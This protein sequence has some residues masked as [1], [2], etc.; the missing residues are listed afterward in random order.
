MNK[1]ERQFVN[2]INLIIPAKEISTR[3][4]NKNLLDLGGK[5]LVYRACE[6]CLKSQNISN[7]FIDTESDKIINSIKDLIPRGLRVI[8]RPASL[9]SNKTSG[10]DLIDFEL[11]KI[12]KCDLV[13]HT[14]STSPLITVETIDKCIESF[15]H[16]DDYDSFFTTIHFQDYLW[17][18]RKDNQ[19]L[20]VNFD[21]RELPNSVDL[22]EYYVETHG[23]YGIRYETAKRLRSRIGLN[24]MAIEIP[25][26]ESLDI[27][28]YEDYKLAE[29]LWKSN[30]H[31]NT[32]K[33]AL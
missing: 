15:L 20:S 16:E 17:E 30:Q 33:E 25:R 19:Y 4:P 21:H 12:G 14:Y 18:R 28:Y 9:A 5:S 13:L 23:L 31:N 8:K 6:K 32:T 24:P 7:V 22:P 29:I 2:K 10:N 26:N 3:L 27:N 1:L 11:S